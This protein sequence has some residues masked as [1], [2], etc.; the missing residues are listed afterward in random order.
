MQRPLKRLIR[1]IL[2]L[3]FF[4]AMISEYPIRAQETKSSRHLFI[5]G[6]IGVCN[7]IYRQLGKTVNDLGP[8]YSVLLGIKLS[9]KTSLQLEYIINHPNDEEP[10]ISDILVEKIRQNGGEN[11]K[12]TVVRSPKIFQTNLLLISLQRTVFRDFFYRI[13]VGFGGNYISVYTVSRDAVL[14]AKTSGDGGYAL[15]FAGGYERHI[16]DRLSL[17]L[18]ASVRWSS[19]EDSS[20]ARFIIGL[21]TIVK[22]DF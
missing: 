9:N 2:P 6:G 5:G 12:F 19:G 4:V 20:S 7:V 1:F 13:G 22:W 21:G 11:F 17:A 18:E 14:E 16:S 10:R 8:S 15:G 3:T